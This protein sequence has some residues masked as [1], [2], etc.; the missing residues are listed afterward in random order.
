MVVHGH[1]DRVDTDVVVCRDVGANRVG[2]AIVLVLLVTSCGAGEQS[3]V[4]SS[5]TVT[6]AAGTVDAYTDVAGR[7]G[8]AALKAEGCQPASFDSGDALDPFLWQHLNSLVWS[9]GVFLEAQV[10]EVSSPRI[11]N[12]PGEPHVQGGPSDMYFR[13][14][15]VEV[16]PGSLSIRQQ[17]PDAGDTLSVLVA[18][19]GPD[20]SEDEL[21]FGPDGLLFDYE[22]QLEEGANVILLGTLREEFPIHGFD[23]EM[24]FLQRGQSGMW[25]LEDDGTTKS[26]VPEYEVDSQYLRTRIREEIERGEVP[27]EDIPAVDS[28]SIPRDYE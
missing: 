16:L 5:S 11:T 27:L 9:S 28:L 19:A 1:S 24:L 10:L 3:F 18:G 7:P 26:V 23:H 4:A 13:E 17:L 12:L 2:V 20:V 22:P 14:M 6:S 15:L 8:F 25:V 21:C